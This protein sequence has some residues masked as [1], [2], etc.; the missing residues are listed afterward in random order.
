M[1]KYLKK[2]ILTFMLSI[3]LA[4]SVLTGC[5]LLPFNQPEASSPVSKEA[6]SDLKVHFI[7]VGQ[8]DS[9]LI[10]SNGHAM[11]IDA[12]ESDQGASVVQYL[13]QQNI[14]ELDYV[15]GTHP[16]SDHIGG[17]DDIIRSFTVHAVILPPV[18]HTTKT[19]EDVLDA[20]SETGLKITKPVVGTEYSLGNAQFEIIAP[21][22]DYKEDLNNWSVGI[23]LCYG[24][25]SFVMCGDAEKEAESD[26]C[27]NGLDL[28]ADVL[29]LGHHGS[30][31][32]T[33]DLFL[34]TVHPAYAVISC[35]KNNSY[36]HPHTEILKKLQKA[37]IQV[38]RT[39][40]SGTLIAVSDGTSIQWKKAEK[41]DGNFI[42]NTNSKK[43]HRPDCS[44]IE[45]INSKNKKKYTGTREELLSMGYEPCKS[46]KP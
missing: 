28:S 42:L 1:N 43:F 46:C 3:F 40:E 44:S 25:T 39:D 36:G 11:L 17:L 32:S 8:G 24:D 14:S 35:G 38:M 26:I 5:S 6:L 45:Q 31:T 16:H 2:H 22:Q 27:A 18:T 30:R 12:G 41:T 19:F 20:I 7:D 13:K 10:E 29:K 23:R 9:I 34:K 33:S 37:G 4:L 21:N 15:V